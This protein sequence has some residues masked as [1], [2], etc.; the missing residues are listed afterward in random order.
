[1]L[2]I[3]QPND[4]VWLLGVHIAADGNSDTKYS[5][6]QKQQSQ[7]STFLQCT[8]MMWWEAWVIY[9][10][11]YLPKVTYPLPATNMPPDKIYKMQL[12]VTV[13][14][15]NKMGY[16]VTFPQAV[17][18]A[19]GKVRGLRFQHLGH[20]Q[21]IQHVIQLLKHLRTSMLNGQLYSALIDA[22]HILAV[23]MQHILEYT[24][25]MPWCPNGWLTITCQFLNSINTMI[26][27]Q[28]LWIPLSCR[29]NDHNIMDDII[30]QMPHANTSAINNVRLYLHIFFL[31]EITNAN[32]TTVLPDVLQNGPRHLGSTVPWPRQPMPPLEAWKHWQW[33]IQTM[34]LCTDSD[35]LTTPLKEWTKNVNKDWT[36]E[37]CINPTTLK[38][39]QRSGEQWFIH[40]PAINRHTYIAYDI[41][42]QRQVTIDPNTMPPATP[43]SNT[44]QT[45]I[46]V[47]LPITTIKPS[48]PVSQQ[49]STNLLDRL[50]TP[51]TQWAAPLWH[52]IR[53]K[54]PVDAL[55][56]HVQWQ[57][58]LI[59]SSDASVDAAKHSCCAWSL[60]GDVTLW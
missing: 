31:S 50:C 39:Y 51:L 43:S 22:Y 47:Q 7:Y 4:A 38:L 20:E 37:W 49:G 8:P 36:W 11:C 53:P 48:A 42:R 46:I 3:M 33:A 32:G 35:H 29:V 45:Y 25:P 58:T 14:F 52:C 34:Y 21:G 15:L 30:K 2:K 13:Q 40:R 16:P 6:L 24:E 54:A 23:S 19:P 12:R 55:L 44:L 5:T 41:H 27:L 57:N 1:M 17:V 28:H 26:T 18:Y 59:L 9:Q 60:H 56:Y 10:Q